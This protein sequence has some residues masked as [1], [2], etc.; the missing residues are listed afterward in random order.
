MASSSTSQR[1]KTPSWAEVGHLVL[2]RLDVIAGI[3]VLEST[4]SRIALDLQLKK[5]DAQYPHW[6][7]EEVSQQIDHLCDRF[8]SNELSLSFLY[9]ESD[10]LLDL[11][12][13]LGAVD[14]VTLYL[15]VPDC[16]FEWSCVPRASPAGQ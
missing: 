13:G 6:D 12:I 14:P 11:L 2:R 5:I 8:S 3:Q 1:T 10:A 15:T 16:P 4:R 7:P 9:Q